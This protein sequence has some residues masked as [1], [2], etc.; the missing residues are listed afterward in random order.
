MER[1]K[2]RKNEDEEEEE[3]KQGDTEKSGEADSQQFLET[4]SEEVFQLSGACE[5]ELGGQGEDKS[6][7][8]K[9]TAWRPTQ[10]ELQ[11]GKKEGKDNTPTSYKPLQRP[12]VVSNSALAPKKRT[13][14]EGKAT[15]AKKNSSS[16]QKTNILHFF[17]KKWICV[18]HDGIVVY[19]LMSTL[20][21]SL[22]NVGPS[23][24]CGNNLSI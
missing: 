11:N 3:E 17:G 23:L 12:L 16:Q 6:K 20:V 22:L 4:L 19:T 7:Q 13:K 8:E 14:V 15:A 9:D 18:F 21:R 5:E 1:G 2:K 24:N 10:Q